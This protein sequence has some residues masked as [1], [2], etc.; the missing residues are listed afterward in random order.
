[1][2]PFSP[3]CSVAP[4]PHVFQERFVPVPVGQEKEGAEILLMEDFFRLRIHDD[5]RVNATA[6]QIIRVGLPKRLK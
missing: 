3:L 1:M 5:N 6:Q 4:T 2:R